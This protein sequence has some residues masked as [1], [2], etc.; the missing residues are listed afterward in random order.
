MRWNVAL[1]QSLEVNVK[2]GGP[3]ILSFRNECVDLN[4]FL[5]RRVKRW[6]RRITQL[7][8]MGMKRNIRHLEI[9]KIT[10]L[11][12]SLFQHLFLR[13]THSFAF[14]FYFLLFSLLLLYLTSSFSFCLFSCTSSCVF[15]LH[16]P[17]LRDTIIAMHQGVSMHNTLSMH[18]PFPPD[19]RLS[20]VSATS[21]M[22]ASPPET[23]HPTH[24]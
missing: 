13:S 4:S 11:F 3:N 14:Y 18:S 9:H 20:I 22:V 10:L 1:N 21:L 17:L 8:I 23:C 16:K 15:F 19:A 7:C 5:K 2:A 12:L 24:R 6:Q